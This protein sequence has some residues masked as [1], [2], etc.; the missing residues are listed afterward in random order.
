MWQTLREFKSLGVIYGIAAVFA[1]LEVSNYHQDGPPV[2]DT[3]QEDPEAVQ[4]IAHVYQALYPERASSYELQGQIQLRRQQYSKAKRLFEKAMATSNTER[5]LH[6]YAKALIL[7]NESDDKIEDAIKT[8]RWNYPNSENPEPSQMLSVDTQDYKLGVA[9]F[10]E[11]NLPEAR[12]RF[13]LDFKN[14]SRSEQLLYNYALVL[15]L[16]DERNELIDE[17]VNRWRKAFPFSE[18]KDPRQ[19]TAELLKRMES[20]KNQ[21]STR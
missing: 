17:V 6:E 12:R 1:L 16:M 13:E 3:V 7:N 14:G 15:I 2:H 10:H 19:A 11:M 5:L 18:R 8:W 21:P 9:A 4:R 20:Q